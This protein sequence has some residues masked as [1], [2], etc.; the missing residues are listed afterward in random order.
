[1]QERWRCVASRT[2]L[3]LHKDGGK[4]N[5]KCQEP[6]SRVLRFRPPGLA[7]C[8]QVG[9]DAAG[10]KSRRGLGGG[11]ACAILFLGDALPRGHNAL[12]LVTL[13]QTQYSS[14]RSA[15]GAVLGQDR[16]SMDFILP[17]TG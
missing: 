3:G 12:L 6:K 5:R 15:A 8:F 17:W 11:G 13:W 7:M 16:P 2:A 10:T 9:W 14:V 1:M 4:G